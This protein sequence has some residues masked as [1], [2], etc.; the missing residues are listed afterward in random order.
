MNFK[1]EKPIMTNGQNKITTTCRLLRDQK[2]K[3]ITSFDEAAYVLL[4]VSS[5]SA[6]KFP[7][8]QR[9]PANRK[10]SNNVR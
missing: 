5:E 3:K 2:V 10:E 4:F 7:L 1:Y 6:A 8:T 9:Q